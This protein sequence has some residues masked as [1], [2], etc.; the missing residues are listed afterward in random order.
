MCLYV[1]ACICVQVQFQVGV[2]QT[3]QRRAVNVTTHK[4]FSRGTVESIKGQV[5]QTSECV[6]GGGRKEGAIMQYLLSQAPHTYMRP[7]KLIKM[8]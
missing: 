5:R 3:G 8:L 7:P 1:F 6:W 4:E 2:S